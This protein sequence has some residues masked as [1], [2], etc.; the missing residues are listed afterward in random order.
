MKKKPEIINDGHET[1]RFL[2]LAKQVISV[3]KE[4]IDRRIAEE[5]AKKDQRKIKAKG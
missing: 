4:E 1:D 5:K 2:A 3:P